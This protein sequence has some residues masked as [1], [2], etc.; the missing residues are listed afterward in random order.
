MNSAPR[1]LLIT[2]PQEEDAQAMEQVLRR[3]L[4]GGVD[5]VLLRK[6]GLDDASL[7]ALA[8]WLRQLTREYD[9]R[10]L[11]HTRADV[12]HAVDGD[13]VHLAAR[14]VGNVTAVRA[15]LAQGCSVS[16]SCHDARELHRAEEEGADFVTLSPVFATRS[17]PGVEP[18]GVDVFESLRRGCALPVL[19]L[20]GVT[21]S[22]RRRLGARGVAVI[23]ALWCAEDPTQAAR[24]LVADRRECDGRSMVSV[25]GGT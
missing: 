18:L 24:M 3:A 11:I 21:P 23:E 8:S 5:A 1:L 13:G 20:G 16:V 12:C 4:G 22:R 9:R 19:A 15:S 2:R 14:D 7:L 17:H 10:L 25:E 6:P